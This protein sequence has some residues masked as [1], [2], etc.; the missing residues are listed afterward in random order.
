MLQ[1]QGDVPD[2]GLDESLLQPE[3][4]LRLIERFIFNLWTRARTKADGDQNVD[5]HN[6][7]N[8]ARGERPERR[9]VPAVIFL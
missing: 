9:G 5:V 7:H 3:P 8:A 4:L 2:K 1:V 6:I